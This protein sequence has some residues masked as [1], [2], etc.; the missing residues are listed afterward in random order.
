MKKRGFNTSLCLIVAGIIIISSYITFINRNVF[1]NSSFGI[2]PI[3]EEELSVDTLWWDSDWLYRNNVT[4]TNPNNEDLID[5]QVKIDLNNI[6]DYNL[7]GSWH[8]NE[9]SGSKIV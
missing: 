5:Y 4:I 8:F 9:N 2:N 6:T 3:S 7:V 1:Y